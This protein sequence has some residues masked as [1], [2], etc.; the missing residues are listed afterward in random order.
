MTTSGVSFEKETKALSKR[1]VDFFERVRY[2]YLSA[3]ENPKEYSKNWKA[4]V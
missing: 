4:T 1:V 3:K 2:A